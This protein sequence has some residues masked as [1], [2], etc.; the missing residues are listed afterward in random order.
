LTKKY[1][2]DIIT[3]R[4][5]NM[6]RNLSLAMIMADVAEKIAAAIIGIFGIVFFLSGFKFLNLFDS[7]SRF[8]IGG[9]CTFLSVG[10]FFYPKWFRQGDSGK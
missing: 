7:F 1:Y 6:M 2:F 5:E 8:S 3:F 9:I 10:Y 4:K